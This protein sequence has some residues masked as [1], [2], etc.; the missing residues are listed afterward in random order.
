LDFCWQPLRVNPTQEANYMPISLSEDVLNVLYRETDSGARRLLRRLRL[1][2]HERDDLRQELLADLI[3]R[4][5]WFDPRKGTLGVFA[6]TIV[7][8]RALR[9]AARIFRE[10]TVFTQLFHEG[11]RGKA[12][13]DNIAEGDGYA[14]FL[15]PPSDRLT[16][17]ERRLDLV[18]ALGLLNQSDLS[19]CV[20]L[21]EHSP[22]EISRS[23]RRSR[24]S[25][26][27]QLKEIRLQMLTAGISAGA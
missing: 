9:I 13:S 14:A 21:I 23:G 26:Y 19:L 22:T 4:L 24:A 16:A 15:G 20:E 1:P 12:R 3:Q 2:E 6:G 8:H 25:L 17:V 27:R 11:E 7:R 10:R 18:R 5:K